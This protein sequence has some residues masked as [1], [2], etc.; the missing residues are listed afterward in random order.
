MLKQLS[1][2]SFALISHAD[3]PFHEGFTA[4][5]GETGAGKS[6]LLKALRMV[7]GDKAQASMV[8]TGEEKAVIE[9]IFDISNE[10]KV[11]Q[12]LEDMGIDSDDEL[13]IR[14]EILENGKGR[15]RVGGNVVNLADL[16]NLGEHLIQMHG[17][18]EQILLRDTRT[19]AQMLDDYAGN[20]SLLAEYTASWNAW[21]SILDK[22]E[23]TKNKATELAAQKDFLKFQFDELSKANLREGEEE[24]LEDKVNIAS[25][26]ETERH[27]LDE[28]QALLGGDNGLLDQMQLLQAKVRTLASR[29]PHYEETQNALA[30][31]SDPFESICK[32]LLRL[33]PAKSLS[34]A[35]IDR[36][37][38]RIALIQKL[39]RKYRTDVAGL[40]ALT[41]QRKQELESLE[42]LD[43][44]IEELSRQMEKH[45]AAM[46]LA[47][48]R[49]TEKRTEA[50]LRFDTAVQGMLRTLGMPKAIFK[51]SVEKA[52]YSANG[53]DKIEFTLAPNPGEGA[54]SLQKAVSG[55]ELSRV[56]LAIKSVMAELDKVPLL[57]FDEVDSG[58]S[59]EVGN[60]IGEALKNLGKHHQVLTI[61]HLHQVASRAKNQLSVSKQV[62]DDRTYTSVKEL[63]NDGRIEELVR[64]LGDNSATVREHAKQLLEKNQ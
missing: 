32:D 23:G 6:V 57:I 41:E 24:E 20:G 50:A 31:V 16:Q 1:I 34:P 35:E 48:K 39:K 10:P 12:I 51:T 3:V 59:G 37:N 22:I 25:K 8:R 21:N 26:G 5:T 11:K 43:A 47:A 33:S 44:D 45:R 54:K 30:E 2:D 18:S 13:V 53:A 63:D 61:T 27:C 52:N 60:S 56:L 62:V 49:L 55:G 28:I 29:I 40:I 42:N 14:R 7:C 19:H 36:A 15:T 9:G 38:A 64:M 58:I 4:I 17:Q 46:E